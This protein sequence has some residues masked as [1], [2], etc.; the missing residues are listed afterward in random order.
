MEND[1]NSVKN[2]GSNQPLSNK[3]I[4]NVHTFNG[5]INE[6]KI[7]EPGVKTS[8]PVS[9]ASLVSSSGCT[10]GA[11]STSSPKMGSRR[12]FTPQFKLQVLE[13][14]RNDSDCKGNQ[15]ATARKYNIHRRQIQKWLQCESSLRS[16]VANIN[17][18]TVKHQFHNISMQQQQS[19]KFSVPDSA[20]YGSSHQHS[21]HISQDSMIVPSLSTASSCQKQGVFAA[22]N[23]AAVVAAAA[24]VKT[25]ASTSS[26]TSTLPQTET[27]V[28]PLRPSAIIGSS[29]NTSATMS[30]L[31]HHHHYGMPPYTHA[32]AGVPL[33]VPI[34]THHISHPQNIHQQTQPPH[35]SYQYH[36]LAYTQSLIHQPENKQSSFMSSLSL[37]TISALSAVSVSSPNGFSK[38]EIEQT[39][40]VDA[41]QF[42]TT[43]ILDVTPEN[44]GYMYNDEQQATNN[45][46]N[47]STQVTDESNANKPYSVYQC[48]NDGYSLVFPHG[49]MDLSLRPRREVKTELLINAKSNG[50]FYETRHSEMAAQDCLNNE[51]NIVDLTYRKRKVSNMSNTADEFPEKQT[52][53]LSSTE[54][55]THKCIVYNS[56]TFSLENVSRMENCNE[57]DDS[58]IEVGTEEKTPPSKPVKLFKPYLLDDCE[59]NFNNIS[60]SKYAERQQTKS[61]EKRIWTSCAKSASPSNSYSDISVESC[62]DNTFQAAMTDNCSD[63]HQKCN[64]LAEVKIGSLPSEFSTTAPTLLPTTFHCPKGSPISSGYESSTSTYS[65]S[66]S[67]SSRSENYTYG[68]TYSINLQ[69]HTIYDN[70]VL[71]PSKHVQRWLDQEELN[72]PAPNSSIALFV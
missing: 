17:H 48:R 32:P 29:R 47:K 65:E 67:K 3:S 23:L 30:P 6:E 35:Q 62:R 58:E 19:Q 14:Y 9:Q 59:D 45:K 46:C 40:I 42:R 18:N 5:E 55:D 51:T 66:S 50:N 8:R 34:L 21:S 36:N 31:L 68:Q 2:F 61:S 27:I 4:S 41:P 71:H 28:S 44:K 7:M 70:I 43:T 38:V 37:P 33:S 13:S 56:A 1:I 10:I 25:I 63:T 49:P 24:G 64:F 60:V 54:K 26:S 20:S 69:M 11:T 12:I 52:K 72:P 53:L 22:A 16:S 15:R 39:N 57:D